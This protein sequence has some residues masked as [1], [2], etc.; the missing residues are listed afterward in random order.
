MISRFDKLPNYDWSWNTSIPKFPE[1]N[2]EMLDQTLSGVQK[3]I[4]QTYLVSDKK[5]CTSFIIEGFLDL[6]A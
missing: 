6:V 4:D 2:A 5:R 3:G 1:L